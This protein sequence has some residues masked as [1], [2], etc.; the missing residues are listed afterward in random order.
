MGILSKI[1]VTT[2]KKLLFIF[3]TSILILWWAGKLNFNC[4][5]YS[6]TSIYCPMCKSTRAVNLLFELQLRDSLLMN[7]MLLFWVYFLGI[8]YIKFTLETLLN[9]HTG[10]KLIDIRNYFKSPISKYILY[11]LTISNILYLN[12]VNK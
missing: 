4:P 7:P 8:S 9:Y 10:I 12:I 3:V 11:C 2:Y 5:I 6:L 1:S